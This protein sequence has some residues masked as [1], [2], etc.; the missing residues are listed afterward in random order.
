[1]GVVIGAPL[2]KGWL[3]V[4]QDAWRENSPDWM[5]ETFKESYF[6]FLDI[7]AD[8]GIPMAELCYP[9]DAFRAEATVYRRWF[10]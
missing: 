7:H 4:P 6:R 5:D 3:A 8:A 2:M 9:V 1:M 10:Q